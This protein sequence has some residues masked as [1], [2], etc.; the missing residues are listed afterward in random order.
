M[1]Q[2]SGNAKN[3]NI[4]KVRKTTVKKHGACSSRGSL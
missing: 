2:N 4:E 1:D 3:E